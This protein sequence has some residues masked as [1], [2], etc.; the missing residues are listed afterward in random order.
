LGIDFLKSGNIKFA[1]VSRKAM[2]WVIAL[3]TG[4][5]G[6]YFLQEAGSINN[7]GFSGIER[8]VI[9][10]YSFV[11]YTIKFIFP[12]ELSPLYPYPAGLSTWQYLSILPF[13]GYLY[14]LIWSYRKKNRKLFFSLWFF[15]VNIFFVLQFLGA[16][17]AYLADRFTYLPYIGWAFGIVFLIDNNWKENPKYRTLSIGLP[18][19]ALSIFC[20]QSFRQC[21][22]WKN[23]NSLWSTVINHYPN[24]DLAYHNQGIWMLKNDQKEEALKNYN[25]AIQLN[26]TIGKY[27]NSRA[28]YYL[29]Q[30][31]FQQA[32]QDYS[33][34]I[35][36][37]PDRPD[38]YNNRSVAYGA[39]AQYDLAL[40]DLNKALSLQPDFSDA[41][42]NRALLYAHT[43]EY[44][45]ALADNLSYLIQHPGDGPIWV[46]A[47]MNARFSGQT[48]LAR[49]YLTRALSLN[50]NDKIAQ[51][52]LNALK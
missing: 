12:F 40:T 47:G 50:P 2:L 43:Q 14:L 48:N 1:D 24:S 32:I 7:T 19:I 44:D 49:T 10:C 38:F 15:I 36:L 23:G 8:I 25:R 30:S 29:K 22:I 31:S 17:Q 5:V 9:G 39:L 16:G 45:K 26:P 37:D 35:L 6:I 20:W 3:A 18:I 41:F 51:S 11:I 46:E 4:V 42:L 33:Q 27:Y 52:E 21:K 13:A 34:A 28:K